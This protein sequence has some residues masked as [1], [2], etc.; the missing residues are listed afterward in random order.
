M[1]WNIKLT[2][3]FLV[4][5]SP[6]FCGKLHICTTATEK[7][8]ALEQLITSCANTNQKVEV[9]SIGETFSFEMKI[10]DCRKFLEK[11][12]DNDVV[13]YVDG[14]DVLVLADEKT[15]L[16]RFYS[17]KAPIVFSVEKNCHPF[18][19]IGKYFPS[20]PTPFRYLNSGSYIGYVKDLKKL[21]SKIGPLDKPLDDQGLFC[22]YY[23]YHP[24]EIKLDYQ[25]ELFLTLNGLEKE[26]LVLN[27][28]SKE[29]TYTPLSVR[30]CLVHGNSVGQVLYQWVYDELFSKEQQ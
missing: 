21:F 7:K 6:L 18:P 8:P 5:L 15:T 25:C 24:K 1:T 28:K 26:D 13:L 11:L 19:H 2:P 27:R 29:V 30:P 14:Y 10:N 16:E 20:S 17:M 12:P 4:V 3:L 22:V 9:C 23:L